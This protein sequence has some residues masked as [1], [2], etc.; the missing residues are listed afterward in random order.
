MNKF[1]KY[2]IGFIVALA[3]VYQFL[4]QIDNHFAPPPIL[5]PNNYVPPGPCVHPMPYVLGTFSPQFNI[6]QA[7]FLQALTDAEAIWEQPI[8]RNLF[9]YEPGDTASGVLKVNL[10]YDYRQEMTDE[11]KGLG[12]NLKNTQ[13][14]YD[15]LNTKYAVMKKQYDTDLGA[16]NTAVEAFNQKNQTYQAEVALS[17]SQGGAAPE[18]YN[19]LEQ[20]RT[21]LQAES[22]QL[23]TTQTNLNATLSQINAIVDPLNNLANSLDASVKNYNTTSATRGESFDQGLYESNLADIN[24]IY[25]YEFK[26]R[27]DLVQVL[28][29]ELGHALGLA[30]VKDPKAIMYADN[31]G[32][33]TKLA[34]EDLAELLARCGVK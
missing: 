28:A 11:L 16:F 17:N 21:A 34:P 2:S 10:I 19:K 24:N 30:H 23:Q 3:L 29:H 31:G 8:G 32:A 7:Y 22:N 9:Q 26:N 4:P 13:A 25:I 14:D 18:E 6:S 5:P 12:I 20:E 1:L 27:T 33:S 15:A